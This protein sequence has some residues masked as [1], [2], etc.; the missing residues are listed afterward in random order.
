ML[1]KCATRYPPPA[2][3]P[4][5]IMSLLRSQFTVHKSRRKMHRSPFLVRRAHLKTGKGIIS[6]V[7]ILF[8]WL[9]THNSAV[10]DRTYRNTLSLFAWHIACDRQLTGFK[11]VRTKD[12][13]PR[14]LAEFSSITCDCELYFYKS[15]CLGWAY[16]FNTYLRLD[17]SCLSSYSF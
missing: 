17:L 14:N 8:R 1:T 7:H 3:A 12:N 5:L 10:S 15:P 9:L 16:I 11:T 13:Y 2:G 6:Q 4:R